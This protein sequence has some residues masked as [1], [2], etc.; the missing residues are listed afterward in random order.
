MKN[1][2][3]NYIISSI[4]F[5][6]FFKSLKFLKF[7]DF[8]FNYVSKFDF[9]RVFFEIIKFTYTLENDLKNDNITFN[10]IIE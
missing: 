6:K 10:I 5:F 7:K 2:K 3:K 8:D 1:Q 4:Q 9:K